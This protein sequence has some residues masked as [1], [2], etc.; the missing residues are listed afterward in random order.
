[1][2]QI[3]PSGEAYY[4][5]NDRFWFSHDIRDSRRLPEYNFIVM[6]GLNEPRIRAR[7]GRPDRTIDCGGSPGWAYDDPHAARRSLAESAPV[8]YDAFLAAD[9]GIDVICVPADRFASASDDPRPGGL[10]PLERPL[11]VRADS[12]NDGKPRTWGPFFSLPAGRW[13]IALD[14]SPASASP[15]RDR[16]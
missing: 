8:L 12:P 5:N 14:Y 9:R 3:W 1:V 13:T 7:Y 6:N 16:W 4:F 2:D 10:Q 15:R 11:D